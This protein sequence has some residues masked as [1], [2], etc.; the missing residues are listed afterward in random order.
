MSSPTCE[1]LVYEIWFVIWLWFGLRKVAKRLWRV[2][3]CKEGLTKKIHIFQQI[4]GVQTMLKFSFEIQ[5]KLAS[6][7]DL[8]RKYFLN[9]GLLNILNSFK[10]FQKLIVEVTI[11]FKLTSLYH[12]FNV[13][14]WGWVVGVCVSRAG[15]TKRNFIQLSSRQ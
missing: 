12:S 14:L 2:F 1:L 6:P 9:K 8:T 13:C 3:F 4:F 11:K 5:L 10:I 15:R 7:S